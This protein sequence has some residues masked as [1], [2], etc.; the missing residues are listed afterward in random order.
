M[1][2]LIL[3]I[4]C[5]SAI[6]AYLSHKKAR[7]ASTEDLKAFAS[8]TPIQLTIPIFGTRGS[9]K[10]LL[11]ST[12]TDQL[13]RER[14]E[15]IKNI[16]SADF[17]T[18][19]EERTLIHDHSHHRMESSETVVDRILSSFQMGQLP[20][21]KEP[22]DLFLSIIFGAERQTHQVTRCHF[23]DV[24]GKQFEVEDQHQHNLDPRIEQADGLICVIDGWNAAYALREHLSFEINPAQ[25]DAWPTSNFSEALYR[26]TLTRVIERKSG[27]NFP[28]WIILTKMD[29]LSHFGE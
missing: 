19:D 17:I 10:T 15:F 8:N 23:I 14:P 29:Q 12:L 7:S 26:R 21:T 4:F 11:L 13:V 27:Q 22:E 9:G 24:P 6:V 1:A 3:S 5:L 16:L 20:E 28:V 18:R 25:V 2:Y